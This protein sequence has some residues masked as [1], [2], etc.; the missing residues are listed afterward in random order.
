VLPSVVIA[1]APTL[2]LFFMLRRVLRGQ[3]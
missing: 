1:L 3:G 2:P